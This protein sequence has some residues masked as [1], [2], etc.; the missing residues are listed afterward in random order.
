MVEIL[1]SLYREMSVKQLPSSNGAPRILL[2]GPAIGIGDYSV[3]ELIK[4]SGGEIVIEEICEGLRNYWG[5]IEN[6][7]DL[8]Q[9]LR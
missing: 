2:M 4:A 5:D 6:E 3:L 9:S 1:T 7:G 8:I